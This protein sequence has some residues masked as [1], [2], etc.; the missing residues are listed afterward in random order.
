M[1]P[2][3]EERDVE[4]S[5]LP[6]RCGIR[7]R[8]EMATPCRE[9]AVQRRGIRLLACPSQRGERR[10]FG[11]VTLPIALSFKTVVIEL[12]FCRR[13]RSGRIM[14]RHCPYPL[15]AGARRFAIIVHQ[16]HRVEL[17]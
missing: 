16:Q 1:V 13:P 4:R 11:V 3:A 15:A 9:G 7:T 17:C 8:R 2:A 12:S 10:A 6:R 14:R 5:G